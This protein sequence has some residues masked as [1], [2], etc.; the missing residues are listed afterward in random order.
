MPVEI[1]I[2]T[3]ICLGSNRSVLIFDRGIGDWVKREISN[4]ILFPHSKSVKRFSRVLELNES[5][6]GE[7]VLDILQNQLNM[8]EVKGV[9]PLSI[10]PHQN[11]GVPVHPSELELKH[12]Y[13]SIIFNFPNLPAFKVE[14]VNKKLFEELRGFIPGDEGRSGI[15]REEY[16]K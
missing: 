10:A 9:C 4:I 2:K 8:L 15:S 14:G 11:I 3:L 6:N 1:P 12:L 7:N 16:K 5:R 13:H